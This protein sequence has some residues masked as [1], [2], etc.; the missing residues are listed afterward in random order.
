MT[1]AS[2]RSVIGILVLAAGAAGAAEPTRRSLAEFGDL[3]TAESAQAALEAGIEALLKAGGGVL[4]VPAN[5]PKGLV[6]RNE[7]QK[8]IN[9]PTVTIVDCRD[10]YVKTCL[11]SIGKHQTC[12][13]AGNRLERRLNLGQT[14]LPH[15]GVYSNQAIQN[16][17]ISG[18]SSYMH[19]LTEPVKTGEDVRCYVDTIRGIWIGQFLNVTG[20]PM[21]YAQPYDRIH[22]K[23]IGWDADRRRNFF[24]CDLE[25]DHPAGA[26]V[27]NKHVVN[28]LQIEGWSN[29]DNQSM[30]LQVTRRHYAV[31]DSFVISGM[32]FYMGDVFSGF[33][34]EGA[35]V[36]NAETV[37]EINGFHSTVEALDPSKDEITYAPGKTNPHILSNSRPLVNMNRKK[38]LT[39]GTVLIVAPGGS[40]KGKSYPSVI[41]GV[42]NVFNYQGGLILGSPDCPWTPDVV[43]RYF[44]LTDPSEIIEADDRSSVG[45]YAK[46]AGRPVYRWYQIK[47]F[48]QNPDGT[49]VVK[50][51]RVRWSAVA[52]GAPTLFD[53][54]NYTRDG[55]EVPLHYAIAPGAW[56]YDISKGWA[57]T[58]ATG[59]HVY[60]THPRKLRLVPNGDRGTPFGFEVGDPVEQAV[61]PDPWQPRPLRI[62]QFDQLPSTMPSSSI[63]V[64]QLGRVQVPRAITLG[65]I[66]R[67]RDKLAAR[68]DK[69]PPWGTALMVESLVNVGVDFAAEVLDAAIIFRQPNGHPQPIRWANKVVGS[70]SL[71]V[72]PQT[73]DF[74]LAGGHLD[75]SGKSLRRAAGLS[76]TAT[77]AR[78]L[79]GINAAVKEGASETAIRFARPE[80]DAGYAV[81]LTPSWL[82]AS[83]AAGKT[84][85]GFTIRFAA[86]APANAAVDWL[87]VR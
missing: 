55:H 51:L 64:Q 74:V 57:D 19:T 40:Y 4:E 17:M 83:C 84:A 87:I 8:K 30:E 68:K 73:G 11:P 24:T 37:G 39:A 26:I 12:V 15:C 16:Y 71:T 79:R 82:T 85:E 46:L 42:A 63:E 36:L 23:T 34:D 3:A 75:L 43:G 47:A 14:S 86:A 28:S 21:S 33:G 49:K 50:I 7:I 22:V 25:H 13:W 1:R 32:L 44:A 27:Y 5:A 65:G 69:K 2:C 18:A 77:S 54:A 20:K 66:I 6:V 67:S 80:A 60:K 35:I 9:E 48:E 53:D 45:G 61:G 81:F 58:R 41:G 52:A 70:S 56:V 59:G 62:R 72:P 29:C 10:G 76:A 38:W 31:G 78:N